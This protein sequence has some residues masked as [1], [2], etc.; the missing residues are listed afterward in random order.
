MKEGLWENLRYD[1]FE[2]YLLVP[3]R[4]PRVLWNKVTDNTRILVLKA[5]WGP[6]LCNNKSVGFWTVGLP[7]NALNEPHHE[8]TCFMLYANNKDADEP[9]ASVQSDQRLCCSLLR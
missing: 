2:V 5:V 4:K 3:I 1:C 8:K 6:D 7:R 9:C